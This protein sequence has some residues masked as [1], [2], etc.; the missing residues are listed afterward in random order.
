M[1]IRKLACLAVLLLIGAAGA[2]FVFQTESPAMSS[3]KPHHTRWGFRNTSPHPPQTLRGLLKFS[4]AHL[5]LP[6]KAVH[7]PLAQNDPQWLQANQ[8]LPSLTWIGHDTFLLQIKGLNVLLDPHFSERASPLPFGEPR[9]L[10]APGLSFEQLPRIDAVLIS[11]NHYDHLDLASVR[12]LYADHG[13]HIRFFVPLGL[14]AWFANIGIA[15]VTELDWWESVKYRGFEFHATPVQHSSART[16]LDRHRTLWA[17]WV[18]KDADFSFYFAGDTGYSPDFAETRKRLGPFDLAALPIGAYAP[19]W[20]MRAMHVNPQ[21]A[22]QIFQDL[23]TR[24]AVGM[25]WGTFRLTDEDADEPPRRLAAA[26]SAAN[27]DAQRFFVMQHGE[28]RRLDFL[29]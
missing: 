8:T 3:L 27:I 15:A 5:R 29:F 6:V 24:Y 28:T 25:H 23:E 4:Y 26:L 16:G 14:K 7:F 19:R 2:V 13:A 17:G 10:V 11:H 1:F 21:E 9:R 12:R 22:V 18:M 20:F